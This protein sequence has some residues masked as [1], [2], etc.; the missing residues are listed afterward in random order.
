MLSGKSNNNTFFHKLP[1][2]EWMFQQGNRFPLY[3]QFKKLPY[4]Q[5]I[6]RDL[7]KIENEIQEIWRIP[8]TNYT[9][10]QAITDRISRLE[11]KHT[12]QEI[13]N[14]LTKNSLDYDDEYDDEQVGDRHNHT[15]TAPIKLRPAY[16]RPNTSYYDDSEYLYSDESIETT[17][18]PM[19]LDQN[20]DTPPHTHRYVRSPIAP[21]IA[22][23]VAAGSAVGGAMV[24]AGVTALTS[25]TSS[26]S[27]PD[28]ATLELY[29]KHARTL[30]DIKINQET[31]GIVVNNVINKIALFETQIIGRTDGTAAVTMEIDLK[32]LI[33]QLQTVIQLTLLK[34]NYAFLAASFGRTS[35]YV[36]PQT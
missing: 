4:L 16:Y 33:R 26:T 10:I 23:G 35:P 36:L 31:L 1:F 13:T 15:A 21:L 17:T 8:S 7:S 18:L 27:T 28:R 12:I 20:T 14:V 25:P 34:Y 29:K 11:N 22:F 2:E 9:M 19:P 32:T 5:R 6:E 3:I 24:G 30:E